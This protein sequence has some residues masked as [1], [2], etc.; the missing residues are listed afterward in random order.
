MTYLFPHRSVRG[1]ARRQLREPGDAAGRGGGDGDGGGAALLA[2][3]GDAVRLRLREPGARR[4][5]PVLL[6]AHQP[7]RAGALFKRSLKQSIDSKLQ[8]LP[9]TPTML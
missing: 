3:P 1:R 6:R 9:Q 2:D 8:G 4:V 5:H 7:G